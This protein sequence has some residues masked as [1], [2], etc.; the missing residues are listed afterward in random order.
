MIINLKNV[1]LRNALEHAEKEIYK[2]AMETHKYNQSKA[3]KAL[4]VSRGTLRNKLQHYYPDKYIDKGYCTAE[5]LK[6]F[7]RVE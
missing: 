3:A 2:Y 5:E 1:P 6:E 7:K 4:G